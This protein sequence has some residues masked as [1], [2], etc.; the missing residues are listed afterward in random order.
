MTDNDLDLVGNLDARVWAARF[1]E[2]FETNPTIVE[3][4]CMVTWFANAIMAGLDHNRKVHTMTAASNS[5][6]PRAIIITVEGPID[7]WQDIWTIAG[8]MRAS[9]GDYIVTGVQGERYPVKPDIFHATY[10]SVDD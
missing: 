8:T 7:E 4:D 5:Y 10:E 1:V 9:R 2:K 6:K 3:Y